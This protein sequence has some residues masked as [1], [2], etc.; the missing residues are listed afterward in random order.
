MTY[1]EHHCKKNGR[2]AS[3]YLPNWLWDELDQ[4]AQARGQTRGRLIFTLIMKGKNLH[5]EQDF[6]NRLNRLEQKIAEVINVQNS[7][8]SW[9]SARREAVRK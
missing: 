7:K 6:E 8:T 9:L 1:R 2:T 5:D 3:I 4:K